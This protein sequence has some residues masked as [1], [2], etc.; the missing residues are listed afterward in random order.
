MGHTISSSVIDAFTSFCHRIYVRYSTATRTKR[1]FILIIADYSV[2]AIAFHF[3]SKGSAVFF[4]MNHKNS[5]MPSTFISSICSLLEIKSMRVTFLFL[6]YLNRQPLL[7][8]LF[9]SQKSNMYGSRD[10]LC[11]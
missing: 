9:L 2:D 8:V 5:F 1:V 6:Y 4:S 10:H 11:P 3:R 7:S